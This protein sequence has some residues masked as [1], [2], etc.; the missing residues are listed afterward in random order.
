MLQSIQE[1]YE[2][3]KIKNELK[4]SLKNLQNE[5]N[6]QILQ[7]NFKVFELQH[8]LQCKDDTFKR[9]ETKFNKEKESYLKISDMKAKQKAKENEVLLHLKINEMKQ[10]CAIEKKL[11]EEQV[12][13]FEKE[14]NKMALKNRDL[15]EKLKGLKINSNKNC[16][17]VAV[18]MNNF[19]VIA[20]LVLCI[21]VVLALFIH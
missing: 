14:L 3:Y 4:H 16:C 21:A 8:A 18:L 5:D 11:L 7:L 12:K 6:P 1:C 9:L 10:K 19:V 2:N 13:R 17:K 15:R 20:I